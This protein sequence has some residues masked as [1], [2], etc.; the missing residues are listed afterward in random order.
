E[1]NF[2]RAFDPDQ[3]H[4][5]MRHLG[6]VRAESFVEI[7]PDRYFAMWWRHKTNLQPI[8]ATFDIEPA[9]RSGRVTVEVDGSKQEFAIRFEAGRWMWFLPRD[10]IMVRNESRT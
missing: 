1:L 7:S 8:D 9:A 4:R 5:V 10:R 2:L 3:Q 6:G